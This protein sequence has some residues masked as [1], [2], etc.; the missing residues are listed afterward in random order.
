MVFGP[1]I[2]R[3]RFAVNDPNPET[4]LQAPRG[5]LRSSNGMG[6]APRLTEIVV[7]FLN[8]F[9]ITIATIIRKLRFK[10]H[11]A[12]CEVVTENS[13]PENHHLR[14][15][16]LKLILHDRKF[17]LIFFHRYK[18]RVSNYINFISILRLLID[19]SSP[20]PIFLK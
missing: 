9:E 1:E 17:N 16:Y 20:L 4:S 18:Q 15:E 3:D 13:E 12:D 10:P 14:G 7:T 19:N 6:E 11:V 5:W 8:D 2:F